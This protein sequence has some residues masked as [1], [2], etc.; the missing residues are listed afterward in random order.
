M[1]EIDA[2]PAHW[3]YAESWVQLLT[4]CDGCGLVRQIGLVNCLLAPSTDD[5]S[6][7][8]ELR[9]GLENWVERSVVVMSG[10]PCADAGDGRCYLW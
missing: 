2:S 9:L 10:D 3:N 6:G 7:T 5:A 8:I 1:L 4:S